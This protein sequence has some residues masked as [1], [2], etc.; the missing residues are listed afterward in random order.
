MLFRSV[1]VQF[2]ARRSD[3]QLVTL[4]SLAKDNPGIMPADMDEWEV[5]E[6]S[7]EDS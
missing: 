4:G 3:Q 6:T 7:P 1:L 2:G 5:S